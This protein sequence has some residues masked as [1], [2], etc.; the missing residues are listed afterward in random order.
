MDTGYATC[1]LLAKPSIGWRENRSKARHS[2]LSGGAPFLG[3][4]ELELVATVELEMRPGLGADAGPVE[5]G[6]SDQRAV[7]LDADAEASAVQGF[8][9]RCVQSQ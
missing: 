3:L 7:G 6:R 2:K 1:W 9:C 5:P 4:D 8:N